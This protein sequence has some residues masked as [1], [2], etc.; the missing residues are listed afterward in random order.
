MR[1][2]IGAKPQLESPGWGKNE[3]VPYEKDLILVSS[4]TAPGQLTE[5]QG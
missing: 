5:V 3:N 1:E 2:N 4:I